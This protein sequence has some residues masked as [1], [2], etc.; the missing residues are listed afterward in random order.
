M[1][2]TLHNES[3]PMDIV[4]PATFMPHVPDIPAAY[5]AGRESLARTENFQLFLK[6]Q[7][8]FKQQTL[9]PWNGNPNV[10][11]SPIERMWLAEHTREFSVLHI[12][13][14]PK[15]QLYYHL[16]HMTADAVQVWKSW[17]PD[18]HQLLDSVAFVAVRMEYNRRAPAKVPTGP[19][20]QAG[21]SSM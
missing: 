3:G 15:T 9:K 2:F 10:L 5:L 19:Q 6:Y 12:H 17:T 8:T 11:L 4:I 7:N 14:H 21:S 20:H 18:D 13:L 1:T 16:S